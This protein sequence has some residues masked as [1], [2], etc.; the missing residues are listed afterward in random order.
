MNASDKYLFFSFL[1]D[2]HVEIQEDDIVQPYK[3][4]Y[5]LSYVDI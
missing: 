4:Q 5:I 2:F 1:D 3:I